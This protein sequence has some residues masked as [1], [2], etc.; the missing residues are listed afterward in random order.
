MAA[1]TWRR[2]EE[3]RERNEWQLEIVGKETWRQQGIETER[4]LIGSEWSSEAKRKRKRDGDGCVVSGTDV[5]GHEGDRGT[6]G[7]GTSGTKQRQRDIVGVDEEHKMMR[8]RRTIRGRRRTIRG[9][10]RRI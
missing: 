5:E 7:D 2:S 8:F 3:R 10:R 9:G 1:G 6:T 4:V